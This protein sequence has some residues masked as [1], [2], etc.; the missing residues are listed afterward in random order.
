LTDPKEKR[1]RWKEFIEELYDKEGKPA[2]DQLDLG[3][4]LEEQEGKPA[5]DQ[6]GP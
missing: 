1:N 5:E 4:C 6:Q 2:E 3:Q